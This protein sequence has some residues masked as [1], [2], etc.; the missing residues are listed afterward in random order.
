LSSLKSLKLKIEL[1]SLY[2]AIG[3][4]ATIGTRTLSN[5]ILFYQL[6]E[7]L[8]SAGE[9]LYTWEIHPAPHY[10]EYSIFPLEKFRFSLVLAPYQFNFV[11]LVNSNY[12][13]P[14][15]FAFEFEPETLSL[16]IKK[17]NES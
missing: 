12:R 13:R 1:Y 3:I 14:D 6:K 10:R 2:S 7:P 5:S 15:R 9:Q 4:A 16:Y 8:K 11:L 17:S